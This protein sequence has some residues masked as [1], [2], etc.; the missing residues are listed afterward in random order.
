VKFSRKGHFMLHENAQY[1]ATV[2]AVTAA[3]IK[4]FNIYLCGLIFWANHH[5]LFTSLH[6]STFF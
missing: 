5:Q 3:N 2:K 1:K 6:A 4:H